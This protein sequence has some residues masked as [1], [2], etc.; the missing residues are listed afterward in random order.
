MRFHGDNLDTAKLWVANNNAGTDMEYTEHGSK[1]RARAFDVHLTGS[2]KRR[3]NRR[4][5]PD[6]Y[7]ATW[8][9]WGVFIAA[10]FVLD[11]TLTIP[12]AYKDERE[13]HLRTDSRFVRGWPEDAHGDHTFRWNGVPFEQTCTKCS[14]VTRWVV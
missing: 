4:S 2:S 8:D 10:L 13:F 6:A 14:A 3:P 5:D 7:A 12:R 9:Q 1:S 11:R